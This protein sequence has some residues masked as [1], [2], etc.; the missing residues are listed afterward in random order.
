MPRSLAEIYL[1]D[2][3]AQF[4]KLKELADRAL[5]RV[6]DEDLAATLDPE[7][8]SVAVLVQHMAGNLRSRWT[9]FL[10]TDGEKPDR[11]RDAEFEVAPGFSRAGLL[12]RWE[13]GWERLFATLSELTADDLGKTVYIRAEP[14]TVPQA[15]HRQM[16]HHAYHI[17]QLVLLA[18]HHAGGGWES[19]SVPRGKSREHNARM[20]GRSGR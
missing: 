19:L 17:G 9:D 20:F 14:H 4:K 2:V 8:N 15:I 10:T 3:T 5:A 12:A 18:R 16:T 1:E 6:R 11:D 7:G 13:K